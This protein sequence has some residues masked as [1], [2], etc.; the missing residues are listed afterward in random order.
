MTDID[1][2]IMKDLNPRAIDTYWSEIMIDH[3]LIV[4]NHAL[5]TLCVAIMNSNLV[6]FSRWVIQEQHAINR[7]QMAG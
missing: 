2:E 1:Q 7:F 5:S 4:I 6:C 3:D